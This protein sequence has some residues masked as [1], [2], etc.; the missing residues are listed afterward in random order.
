M[1]SAAEYSEGPSSRSMGGK[2]QSTG[3]RSATLNAPTAK[4]YAS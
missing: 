4:E 3:R 1:V 2:T